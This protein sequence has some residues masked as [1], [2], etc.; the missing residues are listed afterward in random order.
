MARK[1]L[2][3]D[4]EQSLKKGAGRQL[5]GRALKRVQTLSS[6]VYAIISSKKSGIYYYF[7]QFARL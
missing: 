6:M 1:C 2:Y 3:K 7:Q 5:K 4:I